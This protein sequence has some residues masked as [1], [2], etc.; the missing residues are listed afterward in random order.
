M[1]YLLILFSLITLATL[2]AQE[3]FGISIPN[4]DAVIDL[5]ATNKG[6]LLPRIALTSLT[7]FSPL[8]AHETGMAVYNTTTAGTGVNGITPGYY[9]NDGTK[10]IRMYD[11]SNAPWNNVV[12]QKAA[13]NQNQDIYQMA[14]VAIGTGNVAVLPN[15]FTVVPAVTEDPVKIVGLRKA[16]D[17]SIEKILVTNPT[18]GAIKWLSLSSVKLFSYQSVATQTLAAAAFGVNSLANKEVITYPVGSANGEIIAS[19][20]MTG[21]TTGVFTITDSGLYD[22]SA[23]ISLTV[24]PAAN[25]V[26]G[27]PIEVRSMPVNFTLEVSTNNGTTWTSVANTRS[28]IDTRSGEASSPGIT[29]LTPLNVVLN[30]ATNSQ[31]RFVVQRAIGSSL[32]SGTMS[33]IADATK[34]IPFSKTLRIIRLQ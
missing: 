6:M 9:F 15:K 28:S 13:T 31:I 4:S 29:S 24:L 34:G 25:Y 21:G 20:F 8:T 1:K 16:L 2:Q 3:G 10:W 19:T 7:S 32:S 33:I 23:A 18:D 22:I 27:N 12:T 17:T 30:I 11:D 14:N 5:T 26:V